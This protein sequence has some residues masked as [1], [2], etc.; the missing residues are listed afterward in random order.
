MRF[1]IGFL[2][3]KLAT[4]F[5]DYGSGDDVLCPNE[6]WQFDRSTG[7]C[8]PKQ[9]EYNI[10]CDAKSGMTISVNSGLLFDDEE[11]IQESYRGK[12]FI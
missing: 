11:K 10:N 8:V 5:G 1:S 7:N 3:V 9:S 12:L 4:C 6:S 2:T